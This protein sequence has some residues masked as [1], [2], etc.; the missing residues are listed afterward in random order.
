MSI[1]FLNFE[2]YIKPLIS[3]TSLIFVV[4]S[5]KIAASGTPFIRRESNIINS[6]C[7]LAS[8]KFF[9]TVRVCFAVGDLNSHFIPLT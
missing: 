6:A 5:R 3:G 1:S 4:S 2:I 7:H 8:F 9:K